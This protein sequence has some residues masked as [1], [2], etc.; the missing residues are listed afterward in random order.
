MNV[1]SH[2]WPALHSVSTLKAYL[3]CMNCIKSYSEP[4][5]ERDLMD[6]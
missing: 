2:P 1:S 3:H 4:T 6:I 5:N